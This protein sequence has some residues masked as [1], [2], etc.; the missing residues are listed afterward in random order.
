MKKEKFSIALISGS[1]RKNNSGSRVAKFILNQIKKRGHNVVSI[2]PLEYKLP[3]LDKMYKEYSKEKPKVLDRLAKHIL[4]ADAYIII[5]AEYNHLP[6]PA[7][8]NLLDYFLEEYHF[9]PSAIVTYS[10]GPFGGVRSAVHLR[11]YL[12]ELGMPAI[13][14]SFQVS[15]VLKSLDENGNPIDKNY[16]RRIEKFLSELDWFTQAFKEQRKKGTPY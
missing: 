14:S 12:A 10:T 1:T 5:S 8:I 15:S 13:P 9:K 11:D 7:L 2:D 6:P 3:L 4:K 16:I